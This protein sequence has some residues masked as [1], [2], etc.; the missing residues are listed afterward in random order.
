MKC[1]RCGHRL[2]V[3]YA[4]DLNTVGEFVTIDATCKNC[5]Y[6]NS[7]IGIDDRGAIDQLN[8][9]IRVDTP[10]RPHFKTAIAI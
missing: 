2:Q 1:P 6:R 4:G 9:T 10:R 7:G 8:M 5:D 3:K